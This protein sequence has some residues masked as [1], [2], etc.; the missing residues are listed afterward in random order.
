MALRE[1]Q[2][3]GETCVICGQIKKSGI[4]LCNQL[5]CDS[6]EKKIVETEVTSW[7]YRYYM[8][9]LSA[10]KLKN[11]KEPAERVK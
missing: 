5:I 4:H 9:K 1:H 3:A 6:C 8:N 7:K 2:P 11:V 10:L